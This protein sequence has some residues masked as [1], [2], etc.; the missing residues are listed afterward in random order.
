MVKYPCLWLC[1]YIEWNKLASSDFKKYCHIGLNGIQ[2][3]DEGE[4]NVS[5]DQPKL[6]VDCSRRDLPLEGLCRKDG[7]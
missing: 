5:A 3:T 7:F 2:S 6:F 4:K 1:K